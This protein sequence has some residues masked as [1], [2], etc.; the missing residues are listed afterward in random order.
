MYRVSGDSVNEIT[1]RGFTV[2]NI[3]KEYSDTVA[4]G[5]IISCSPS[6]TQN[7]GTKIDVVVSLGV[8]THT[9]CGRQR[10]VLPVRQNRTDTDGDPVSVHRSVPVCW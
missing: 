4:E 10:Q 8:C 7:L 3:T 2:G 1:N 5:K 9:Q 6:G